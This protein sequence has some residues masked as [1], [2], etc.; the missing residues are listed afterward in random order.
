M[1][2]AGRT[3]WM[4]ALGL[5]MLLAVAWQVKAGDND[6]PPRPNPPRLV[7]DLANMMNPRQQEELEAKLVEFDKTS[8]TQI[9]VVTIKSLG[10]YDIS[11]YAIKL[12][13]QWGIGK[14]G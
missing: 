12:A 6:F 14:A 13:N 10:E 1:I 11:D 5:I 7:N 9:A 4:R 3:I 8:S 2:S